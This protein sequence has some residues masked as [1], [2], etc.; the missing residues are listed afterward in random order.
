VLRRETPCTKL[1]WFFVND[2]GSC[3]DT[4]IVALGHAHPTPQYSYGLNALTT[5]RS[6]S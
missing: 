4:A 2:T 3:Y 1:S 6:N 5:G